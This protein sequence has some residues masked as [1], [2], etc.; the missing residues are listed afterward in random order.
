M[1]SHRGSAP[2]MHSCKELSTYPEGRDPS[3][4][5]G[6]ANAQSWVLLT[7]TVGRQKPVHPLLLPRLLAPESKYMLW[8]SAPC[9]E[10]EELSFCPVRSRAETPETIWI[11]GMTGLCRLWVP[12]PKVAAW[13]DPVQRWF[14]PP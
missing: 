13:K 8:G 11:W 1:A 6:L 4:P 9:W 3:G 2:T 5:A 14:G 12:I 10:E 7:S